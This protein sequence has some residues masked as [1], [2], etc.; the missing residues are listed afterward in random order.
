[1][2]V[3]KYNVKVVT[4]SGRVRKKESVTKVEAI[5]FILDRVDLISHGRRDI[6]NAWKQ[7]LH[8]DWDNGLSGLISVNG[9]KVYEYYVK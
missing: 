4:A 7:K 6:V 3:L 2:V 1:M 5:K 8:D 9:K